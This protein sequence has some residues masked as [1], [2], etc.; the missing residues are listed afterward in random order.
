MSET[1]E[2]VAKGGVVDRIENQK[3]YVKIVSQSACASCHAN[4]ACSASDISE[5]MIEVDLADAG[6]VKPGEFV[7]VKV[8]SSAGNL[9][10]FYGYVF[11]FL[12]VLISLIV[13]VNF[14]SEGYAGLISLAALLPYY[15]G[16]YLLR[17][18][19]ARRFRFTIEN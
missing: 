4:V 18:K 10:L 1:T 2:C 19:I 14:T 7:T 8:Q 3:V 11:P 5:K 9:A 12:L 13:A 6:D 17:G 15:L 16:L